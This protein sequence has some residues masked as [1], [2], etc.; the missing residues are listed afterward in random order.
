MAQSHRENLT[1]RFLAAVRISF[2]AV[3]AASLVLGYF[4]LNAYV[5]GHDPGKSAN[6]VAPLSG[7]AADLAFYDLQLVL[8]QSP[9]LSQQEPGPMTWPLQIAR[10][11]APSVLLYPVMELGIALSAGR[12]RR[13][14]QRR[15]RGHAVV[16]GTTRAADCLADRLRAAGTRVIT[17]E[18][19]LG[20]R[21]SLDVVV[22]DPSSPEALLDAAAD[23]AAC[24][25]ACLERGEDNAA[26]VTAV[27]R[28]RDRRGR[29]ARLYAL[30]PDLDLCAGLRARQWSASASGARHLDFFNPDEL[31]ARSVVGRDDDAFAGGPPE[32]AVVGTG[33][34]ARS[35]LVEFG[36]QW[37]ARR[38]ASEDTVHAILLGPDAAQ[39][40]S[41]LR[42]RYAF[43]SRACQIQPRS[44][45][46]DRLLTR[47]RHAA[48][49]R[50][51][52]L[53]LCHEDE[54]EALKTALASAG[55]LR[56]A[57]GSIVVRLDKTA[58][59]AEGFQAPGSGSGSGAG[60]GRGSGFGLDSLA[61]R[62]RMVDVIS[63]S[64]DPAL[65]GEDLTEVLARACHQRYLAERFGDGDARGAR[66]SLVRWEDLPEEY[67]AANRDLAAD[68]GRKLAEIGCLL[69]PR[70]AGEPEFA[71]EDSEVELLAP[72]EHERW[73]AERRR[74]GWVYGP[75][76][77]NAKKVHPGL[78][79]W[80]ELTEELRDK[81]RQA[82]LGLPAILADAGLVVVRLGPGPESPDAGPGG[83]GGPPAPDPLSVPR[84]A[85]RP[86]AAAARVRVRSGGIPR[87]RS[88]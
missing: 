79:P 74:R 65:V 36:R 73:T 83:G 3:G 67:R 5:N 48:A 39:A 60:S 27:E 50:L 11:G 78:L 45:P 86:A 58:A 21:A 13:A 66:P 43:L 54:N 2:A 37:L 61:G 75:C 35:V 81:D 62:L 51:R 29:P 88:R 41:S 64:C 44:E 26:I 71:Y 34:F 14:R 16:C 40:A 72:Q 76:R 46:L 82:V 23:R 17:I 56:T 20:R 87:A 42:E 9:P 70:S 30:V 10:F 47:R 52:R 28:I 59:M 4:G 15:A 32:I 77:D 55:Y 49:P 8:G 6:R 80:A 68:V 19:A 31:A 84:P 1:K 25:Y 22:G 63:E 18:P 57:V 33:A 7:T 85:R 12:I 53:Y 69:T 38:G 24:V